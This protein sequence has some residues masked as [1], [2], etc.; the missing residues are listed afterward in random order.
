MVLKRYKGVALVDTKRGI[1]VVANRKRI[2]SLP[3]GGTNRGESRKD[4]IIRELEEETGLIGI[5][6][7]YLFNYEG[8]EWKA[9]SGKIIKNYAKVFLVKVR[10]KAKP[11]HEIKHIAFWKE[12]SKIRISWRSK[13]LINAYLEL[14][15]DDKM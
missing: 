6:A 2:F 14:K 8:K 3:G 7:K 1:L 13:K 11:K 5:N 15:K 4:A 10:G 12:G 9:H